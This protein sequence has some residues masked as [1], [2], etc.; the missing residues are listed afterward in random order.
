MCASYCGHVEIV[1][2]LLAAGADK[3]LIALNGDTAFSNAAHT[4]ASTAAIRALLALAP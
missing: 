3:H 4:P 1:R 2:A